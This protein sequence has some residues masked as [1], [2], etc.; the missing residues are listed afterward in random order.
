MTPNDRGGWSN[1]WTARRGDGDRAG[2]QPP[3]RPAR[4]T[5]RQPE[6]SKDG[7]PERPRELRTAIVLLVILGAVLSFLGALSIAFADLAATQLS[8]VMAESGQDVPIDGDQFGTLVRIVGG[9]ILLLGI[10]HAVAVHG[11]RRRAQWGRIVAY[12]SAGI[13]T[14]FCL[15][16]AVQGLTDV[17]TIVL[18]AA[19][20]GA[21]AFLAQ[22]P[23]SEHLRTDR[24]KEEGS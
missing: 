18:L 12:V 9:V 13:V 14:A 17:T 22:G 23:V 24:R 19:A 4:P 5:I 20:V 3:R 8:D 21:I 10:G 7:G 15:M 1:R 16:A 11:L 6:E 2:R